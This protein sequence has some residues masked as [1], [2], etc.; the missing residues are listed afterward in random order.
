MLVTLTLYLRLNVLTRGMST[1]DRAPALAC[2][3][4][5]QEVLDYNDS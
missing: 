4:L 2:C 1:R 3:G 5:L